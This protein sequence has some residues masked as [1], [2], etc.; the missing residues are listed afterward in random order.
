MAR[1]LREYLDEPGRS[2]FRRWFDRLNGPAAA[3]VT[4]ALKRLEAGNDSNTKSV[5]EGVH[6]LKVDFGPGYRVYFGWQGQ[7]LIIL[8]AGGSKARQQQDI[9]QAKE[10]W[11]AHKRRVREDR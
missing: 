1:T 11:A 9:K 7:Q 5:G 10:L 8:L 3:K 6:E 4:I 2:A